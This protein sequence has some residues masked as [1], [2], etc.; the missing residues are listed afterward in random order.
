VC[1]YE[2]SR[3]GNAQIFAISAVLNGRDVDI[4]AL[5]SD[6]YPDGKILGARP[7]SDEIL[8]PSKAMI[9]IEKGDEVSF[10]YYAEYF[11][12]EDDVDEALAHTPEEEWYE[13][14]SCKSNW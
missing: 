14:E 9:P 2:I 5:Y 4:I 11:W 10:H 1:L 7:L 3:D 12:F 13:G 8:A 6:E